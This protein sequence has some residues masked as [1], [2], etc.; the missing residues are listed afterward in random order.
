LRRA[1]M[2]INVAKLRRRKG[3]LRFAIRQVHRI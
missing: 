3:G 1:M 2:H